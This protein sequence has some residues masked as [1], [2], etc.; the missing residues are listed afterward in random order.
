[1]KMTF[2]LTAHY[3]AV[4]F[5]VVAPLYGLNEALG[6]VAFFVTSFWYGWRLPIR[7]LFA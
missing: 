4:A 2:R 5:L 3:L 1:M 6:N 7:R